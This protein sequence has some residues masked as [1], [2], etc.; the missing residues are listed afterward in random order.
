M[1]SVMINNFKPVMSKVALAVDR[2][3]LV[4][5]KHGKIADWI[6]K[7]LIKLGYIDYYQPYTERLNYERVTIDTDRLYEEI[8]RT[9]DEVRYKGEELQ[10][11]LV[12]NKHYNSLVREGDITSQ[13]I[14]P[15][16]SF[17]PKM[18]MGI[19]IRLLPNIDGIV[20]VP[21]RRW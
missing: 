1:Y 6:I 9:M 13:L 7:K 14:I 5:K 11:I 12:G 19:E 15:N 21:K 20:F 16:S 17:T 18:F 3:K 2:N 8:A 10:M 4:V